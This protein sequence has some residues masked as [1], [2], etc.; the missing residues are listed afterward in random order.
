MIYLVWAA[1]FF[2]LLISYFK[3]KTRTI[4]ALKMSFSSL[5]KLTSG[6]LGMIFMVG[7]ILA[8]IPKE[9]LTAIFTYE[10]FMGYVIVAL[11][12]AIVTI[13]APIAFPLAGSL[14]QAGA[15][16]ST[17]ASFITTLTMVGIVTLPLEITYFGKRFAIM[18]QGF[19]FIAAIVI[20]LIMGMFL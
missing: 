9:T 13:P 2:F 17:L 18:R 1:T 11:V 6:I 20:G 8:L 14:L 15:S 12:G 3:D 19:S 4:H 16:P 7:L 5:R 10:G